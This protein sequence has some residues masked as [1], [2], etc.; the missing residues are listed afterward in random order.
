MDPSDTTELQQLL[1]MDLD[2]IEQLTAKI[3]NSPTLS[4]KENDF[5]DEEEKKG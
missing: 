4:R 5:I 1:D 2:Q 3:N